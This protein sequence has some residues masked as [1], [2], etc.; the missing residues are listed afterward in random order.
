MESIT[1]KK[2][3]KE[4]WLKKFDDYKDTFRRISKKDAIESINNARNRG[5]LFSD[6]GKPKIGEYQVW[7]YY[8]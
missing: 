2:T 1:I 6:D 7:G 4:I 5:D 3:Y 8:N